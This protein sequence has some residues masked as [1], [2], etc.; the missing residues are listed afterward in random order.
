MS[1]TPMYKATMLHYF[2]FTEWVAERYNYI[3]TVYYCWCAKQYDI[4]DVDRHKS[5]IELF[6]YWWENIK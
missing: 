1:E 5:T 3:G 6:K 4:K 2:Q